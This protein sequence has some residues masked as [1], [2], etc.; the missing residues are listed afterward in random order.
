M[1]AAV[2]AAVSRNPGSRGKVLRSH[3]RPLSSG[4]AMR[5]RGSQILLTLVAFVVSAA[6]PALPSIPDEPAGPAG[7]APATDRLLRLIAR[8][9][10]FE[11]PTV[12]L[13]Q[14]SSPARQAFDTLVERGESSPFLKLLALEPTPA[15]VYGLEGLAAI[16]YRKGMEPILRLL[17]DEREV[18]LL[19]CC[20]HS[21]SYVA[22]EAFRVLGAT[23]PEAEMD[24]LADTIFREGVDASRTTVKLRLALERARSQPSVTSLGFLLCQFRDEKGGA[25]LLDPA[26]LSDPR[27]REERIRSVREALGSAIPDLRIAALGAARQL[28]AELFLEEIVQRVADSED[29]VA[30]RGLGLLGE[31]AASSIGKSSPPTG[32]GDVHTATAFLDAALREGRR[33]LDGAPVRRRAAARLFTEL[34]AAVAGASP[35]A[36][37]EAEARNAAMRRAEKEL[38]AI[39]PAAIRQIPDHGVDLARA[40]A[41]LDRD[42]SRSLEILSGD[43]SDLDPRAFAALARAASATPDGRTRLVERTLALAASADAHWKMRLYA[44]RALGEARE[45]AAAP[46]LEGLSRDSDRRL[47]REASR[48]LAALNA[49][50]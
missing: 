40:L 7:Q 9:P 11:T 50:P 37:P 6:S 33:A 21:R 30:V 17:D 18:D 45:R 25:A 20:R 19:H 14:D 44:V 36:R 38:L 16:G 35:V 39:L 43:F 47:A 3:G 41:Q 5:I 22:V 34:A 2:G 42:G 48:A 8:A 4:S 23:L 12:G 49:R 15:R 26:P 1:G 13:A 27:L 31:L 32:R 24:H 29:E 10:F 28:D 46:L